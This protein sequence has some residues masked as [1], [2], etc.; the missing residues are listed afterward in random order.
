MLSGDLVPC[1]D[2]CGTGGLFDP[3]LGIDWTCPTCSGLGEV[4]A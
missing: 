4:P 2:C 3:G 1:E